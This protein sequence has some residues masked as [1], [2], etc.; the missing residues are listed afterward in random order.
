MS[1]TASARVHDV[2]RFMRDHVAEIE[3]EVDLEGFADHRAL[4]GTMEIDPLLG[5]R[6][7]YAFTFES[8]EGRRCRFQG[9]KTVEF[10]RFLDTMTTLPGEIVDEKGDRLGEAKLRFDARS[11]L[12]KFM[13]SF[14]PSR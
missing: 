7:G 6:I 12:V 5:R 11:D 14:R 10:L 1:F 9:E 13:R 4:R 8:N 3:G 2:T